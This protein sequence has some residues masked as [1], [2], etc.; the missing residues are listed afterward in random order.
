VERVQSLDGVGALP[1]LR[2]LYASFNEIDDCSPLAN[3]ELLETVDLEANRIAAMEVC[4]AA[5]GWLGA[6]KREARGRRRLQ[7]NELM[8]LEM[9]QKWGVNK[10][11]SSDCFRLCNARRRTEHVGAGDAEQGV[12]YLGMCAQLT[13]LSIGSNPLCSTPH[14]RRKVAAA[15]PQLQVGVPSGTPPPWKLLKTLLASP[16]ELLASSSELFASPSNPLIWASPTPCS[17]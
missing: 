1:M 16:S 10:A 11:H 17:T 14:L 13:A 3:C 12:E 8:P 5:L 4:A 7:A 15:V 2:E 9:R 6:P